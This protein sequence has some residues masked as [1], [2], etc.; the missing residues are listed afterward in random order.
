LANTYVRKSRL[1][2]ER[3]VYS[4]T[5]ITL[6]KNKMDFKTIKI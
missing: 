2:L 1:K 3:N 6:N 4:T 5:A